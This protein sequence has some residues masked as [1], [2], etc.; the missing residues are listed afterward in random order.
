MVS[1]PQDA[2]GTVVRI[3]PSTAHRCD[4]PRTLDRM[5]LASA[6][7][8]GVVSI[9][10]LVDKPG[11]LDLAICR[12]LEVRELT[13]VEHATVALAPGN[14]DRDSPNVVGEDVL[15]LQLEAAIRLLG[16][17]L[18][19][20][21]DLVR[22]TVRTGQRALAANDPRRVGCQHLRE[23][24]TIAGGHCGVR[25]SDQR[26]V[27]MHVADDTDEPSTRVGDLERQ[28]HLPRWRPRE[29]VDVEDVNRSPSHL[30]RRH[31]PN[32]ANTRRYA[33][34][35]RVHDARFCAGDRSADDGGVARRW[36]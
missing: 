8:E 25:L 23:C 18:P 5:A 1:V 2:P 20:S 10:V 31:P 32:G 11:D 13:L 28:S 27:R 16:D 6:R 29:P 19:K 35:R 12:K 22:T 14:D 17:A 26:L 36:T 4:R 30:S 33:L 34:R 15:Q 3:G 9:G 7:P 24:P 21:E